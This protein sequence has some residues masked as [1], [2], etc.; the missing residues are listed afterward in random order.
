MK[1]DN[2]EEHLLVSIGKARFSDS[3]RHLIPF[4]NDIE[5]DKFLNDIENTPH[6]CFSLLDG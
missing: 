6:A 5:Q 2:M 1:G 3:E 4:V